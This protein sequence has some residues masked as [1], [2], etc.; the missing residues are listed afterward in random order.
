[1]ETTEIERKFLL[2]PCSL[3]KFLKRHKLPYRAVVIEQF[4][5]RSDAEGSERYRRIGDRYIHTVKSGGGIA[6]REREEEVDQGTYL[7][8][9]E[10]AASDLIEKVRY[11]VPVGERT[12]E[13]DAFRGALRGLNLLE[14]E[15]GSL[16]EARSFI[17]PEPFARLLIAD[18]SENPD[19][20][21]GAL[22]RKMRLPVLS[23]PLDR[24]LE[25]IAAQRS[26]LLKASVVVD[27][28]PFERLDHAVRAI[29][30]TFAETMA[31]NRRAILEGERDPERLHQFR[32]A[33]RKL[34]ALFSRFPEAFDERWLGRRLGFLREL[35]E[36]TGP[37]RD[38]DVALERID[39]YRGM[40]D[41]DAR[42][43]LERL[44]A[45]LESRRLEERERLRR[46]LERESV[47]SELEALA[48]YGRGEAA[49]DPTEAG[50][51]PV[52][53]A[54]APK[55][56]TLYKT[57]RREGDK[58]GPRSS[59]REYHRL[60]IR[61]KKFRYLLEFFAGIFDEEATGELLG[62]L[63]EIQTLLGDHQD[64]TVQIAWLEALERDAAFGGGKSRKML[65]TLRKALEK[66]RRRLRREFHRTFEELRGGKG[67]LRRVICRD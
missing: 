48:R 3:K 15:F 11:R 52:L 7:A 37:L 67:L 32:V 31:L 40:L 59:D 13:L 45:M 44:R 34:R 36:A 47:H 22:S 25:R 35:A 30:F 28:G 53:P 57:I 24:I 55:L 5:L 39:D 16:R 19:F 2:R 4:Y 21:N 38:L 20:T 29:L 23:E 8:M 56:K 51:G 46:F 9:K 10:Q 41:E 6:R 50:E 42:E 26:D 65:R 62:I 64:C 49:S 61:F 1:M 33:L 17:L 58:L 63:K 66:R 18:V 60:R 14:V 12:F 43:E 27:F 54:L